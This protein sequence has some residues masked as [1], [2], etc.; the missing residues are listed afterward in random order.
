MPQSSRSF[1]NLWLDDFRRRKEEAQWLLCDVHLV[2]GAPVPCQGTGAKSGGQVSTR[3]PGPGVVWDQNEALLARSDLQ[4]LGP[5]SNRPSCN[6]C[7]P[8]TAGISPIGLP[9]IC[10]ASDSRSLPALGDCHTPWWQRLAAL[11]LCTGSSTRCW[12]A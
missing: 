4:W 1:M 9:R 3:V 2:S 11:S 6:D 12:A 10:T 8:K 5:V 7:C